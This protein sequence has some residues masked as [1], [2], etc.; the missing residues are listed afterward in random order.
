MI[1]RDGARDGAAERVPADPGVV[2]AEV[3]HDVD[4]ILREVVH[5]GPRGAGL[6]RADLHDAEVLFDED[7]RE[8]TEV[9]D[10]EAARG[11]QHECG[12]GPLVGV[13]DGTAIRF[14][15]LALGDRH[16]SLSRCGRRP[17][18]LA[19]PFHSARR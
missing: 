16:G 7:A 19:R 9:G 12:A 10:V 2:D 5:R 4:D 11:E 1:E 15:D 18:P 8:R 13:R 17:V 14:E 6:P 3:V